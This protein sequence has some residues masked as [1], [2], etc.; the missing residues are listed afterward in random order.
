MKKGF[1]LIEL[2]VTITIMMVVM[3]VSLVAFNATRAS[4]R[5]ARRKADVEA[6]RSALELY[7]SDLGGYP[8]TLALLAPTYIAAIP[9]DSLAGRLYSYTPGGTATYTLC[10]AVENPGSS[11]AVAGCGSCGSSPIVCNYK[12]TNP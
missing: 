1:T 3:G 7:R 2:L 10:A 11:G 9:T 4:A 5:D 6:L 8:A 12:T